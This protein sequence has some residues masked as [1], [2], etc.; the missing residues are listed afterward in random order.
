M[1]TVVDTLDEDHGEK[2]VL[3][4]VQYIPPS[5]ARAICFFLALKTWSLT[6]SQ[7]IYPL[8][9]SIHGLKPFLLI[10]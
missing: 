8:V 10:A 6:S 5:V 3:V 9:L 4:Y 1:L 7:Y 2:L